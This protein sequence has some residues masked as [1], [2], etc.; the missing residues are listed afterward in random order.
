MTSMA[1][2]V[3]EAYRLMHEG[4]LLEAMI[5]LENALCC[6]GLRPSNRLTINEIIREI[7]C[8]LYKKELGL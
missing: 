3:G 8:D 4:R 1:L 2:F 6:R 7:G 5:S